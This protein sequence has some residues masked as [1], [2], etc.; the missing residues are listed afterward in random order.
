[1]S[2]VMKEIGRDEQELRDTKRRNG[3]S[4][5]RI[6]RYAIFD[7]GR[8]HSLSSHARWMLAALCLIA[9]FRT[10]A[11]RATIRELSE[12]T[13]IGL[14]TVPK[15]LKEL[16]RAGLVNITRPFGPNREG[17][18]EIIAWHDIVVERGEPKTRIPRLSNRRQVAEE[19]RTNRGATADNSTN[20]QG[21]RQ[22]RGEGGVGEELVSSQEERLFEEDWGSGQCGAL[23]EVN[24]DSYEGDVSSASYAELEPDEVTASVGSVHDVTLS[25]SDAMQVSSGL[26]CPDCG[27]WVESPPPGEDWCSC[28]F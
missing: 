3:R 2:V 7:L 4:W 10:C 11:V 8:E 19:P 5:Q 13:G 6:D 9:D 23:S 16:A 14:N 25:D 28:A 24:W 15:A 1:M 17:E 12:Q 22:L 20:D 18:V 26:R 27:G 21:E